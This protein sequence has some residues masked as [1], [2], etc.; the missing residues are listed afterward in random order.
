[1]ERWEAIARELGDYDL[2]DGSMVKA[3]S[4]VPED[5][6]PGEW[7]RAEPAGKRIADLEAKLAYRES[8]QITHSE[9]CWRLHPTCAVRKV[10]DLIGKLDEERQE[11]ARLRGIIERS[12]GYLPVV[13][14]PMAFVDHNLVP[15]VV[16]VADEF[17]IQ[18]RQLE[19]AEEDAKAEIRKLRDLLREV[20]GSGVELET[21]KYLTVQISP[22]TWA[23][24]QEEAKRD[25][26]DHK[27]GG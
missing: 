3:N 9:E 16:R 27:E 19:A 6:L 17:A 23:R 21:R 8:A 18:A 1:M 24:V 20:A 2:C 7:V 26:V 25:P 13:G 22:E 10:E 15:H 4:F 12:F 11:T 14:E 5:D